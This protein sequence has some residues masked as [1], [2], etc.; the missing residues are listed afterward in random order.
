MVD[1]AEHNNCDDNTPAADASWENWPDS[2]P[3][4]PAGRSDESAAKRR[5]LDELPV[6]NVTWKD[7]NEYAKW[8]GGRL[9]TEDEWERAAAIDDEAWRGKEGPVDNARVYPWGN[10]R[11]TNKV[12][13]DY[14][15]DVAAMLPFLGSEPG[16]AKVG[17]QWSSPSPSG[18]YDMLGNAFE[19]CTAS[20][21]DRWTDGKS[22][23]YRGWAWFNH[24]E[25]PDVSLHARAESSRPSL[26]A[27]DNLGLRVF[28]DADVATVTSRVVFVE[29]TADYVSAIDSSSVFVFVPPGEVW[30]GCPAD[31]EGWDGQASDHCHRPSCSN[32]RRV[33]FERGYY[34]G[35]FE[36]TTAQFR[37]FVQAKGHRPDRRTA[38]NVLLRRCPGTVSLLDW[39]LREVRR[40]GWLPE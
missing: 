33:Q 9:P 6:V 19:W 17:G 22:Q 12:Q 21:D 4:H 15:K 10:K 13:S 40:R 25:N 36:V 39:A 8:L 20:A 37:T 14:A 24:I 28:M 32:R 18:A 31:R 34:I 30:L 1:R 27:A 11:S 23:P 26:Y 35:K 3:F 5:M 16:L 38:P 7:A 2:A 29:S